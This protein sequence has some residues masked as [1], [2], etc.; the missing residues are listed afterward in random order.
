MVK[1]ASCVK[2]IQLL[3]CWVMVLGIT[4]HA[5]AQEDQAGQHHVPS[6]LIDSIQFNKDVAYCDVK[7]P[8]EQQDVKERL[9]KEVLLALWDRP[10]VILWMKRAAKFFP[11]IE[12]ILKQHD[13]PM[14]FKYV[15]LI[16]SALRPH[17]M[18]SKRATGYWQFVRATGRRYGL[19]INSWVDDRRNIFTST[20]AA[21]RYLKDLKAKFGSDL[22]ALAAYNMGEYGLQKEIVKQENKNFFSLYLPL[23]TQRYIFKLAAAKI[24]FENKEAYGFHLKPA[25]LYPEFA[26]DKVNFK[27]DAQVPILLIAKAAQVP[28]KTIK[29]YNPQLRGYHLDAGDISVL[30]PK[31]KAK[32]FKQNFAVRYKEWRKDNQQKIHIVKRGESLALIAQKYRVSLSALLKANNLSRKSMIH[33]GDRLVVD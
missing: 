18:S 3:A 29:D 5:S 10:Q 27:I 16:E 24:I 1:T 19:K 13:L 21:C 26:F 12:T 28:F 22:L 20:H 15:P 2:I 23:E 4:V 31:G 7:F 9:E 6:F 11:H 14:D 17:A 32:N 25:D 33:P 30:I 8:L